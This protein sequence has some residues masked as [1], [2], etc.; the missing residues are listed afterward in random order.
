MFQITLV[1]GVLLFKVKTC[2]VVN[3]FMPSNIQYVAV[4]FKRNS[5]GSQPTAM[6]S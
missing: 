5:V 6:C 4:K 1:S 3:D 2:V